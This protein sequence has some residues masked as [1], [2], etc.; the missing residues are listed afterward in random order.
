MQPQFRPL[1]PLFSNERQE[2]SYF[3][4]LL[5]VQCYDQ[6]SLFFPSYYDRGTIIK[7]RTDSFGILLAMTIRFGYF[8]ACFALAVAV[9]TVKASD[10]R[11]GRSAVAT[12]LPKPLSDVS[13]SVG[14]DGLI[15]IAGG[16][17]SAYGNQYDDSERGFRCKSVSKSFYAFDQEMERFIP[18]ED[19]PQP[20]HRHAAVAINNQIWVVGGRDAYDNVIGDVDV[21]NGVAAGSTGCAFVPDLRVCLHVSI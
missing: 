8:R 4:S 5:R 17:D 14:E 3:S 10:L 16:C 15:Y 12:K 21:S 19:M 6:K 18:L 9:G 11:L 13:A 2:S 7:K 20:R 1:P